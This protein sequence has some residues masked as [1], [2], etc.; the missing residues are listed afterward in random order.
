[1]AKRPLLPPKPVGIKLPQ[2]QFPDTEVAEPH[3]NHGDTSY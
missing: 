2:K 1:M 3:F